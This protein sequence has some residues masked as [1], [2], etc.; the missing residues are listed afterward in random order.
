V[1]LI[2]WTLHDSNSPLPRFRFYDPM[3]LSS[4]NVVIAYGG[5]LNGFLPGIE[6][7]AVPSQEGSG[8]ALNNAGDLIMLR[9][10]AGNLITRIVYT[11]S[12]TSPDGSMTRYPG[13]NGAFVA[14][15]GVSA[16]LVTPGRQYNGKQWTEPGEVPVNVGEIAAALNANGS[17]TLTWTA[18]AGVTYTVR[19]A[20]SVTG[21]FTPLISGITGGSY[22]DNSLS[23]VATRFYSVSAP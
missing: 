22:T 13:I 5:P 18:Q 16:L 11:Q 21:P 17:V 7:P 6:E 23:G 9:N 14:Q 2:N 8:I 15:A 20:A 12:Q 3:P 1:D 19:S 4:S 10:A